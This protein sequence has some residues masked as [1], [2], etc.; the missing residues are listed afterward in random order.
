[1]AL[2][3]SEEQL[4]LPEGLQEE[5]TRR[6][7]TKESSEGRDV[8]LAGDVLDSRSELVRAMRVDQRA[9][10]FMDFLGKRIEDGA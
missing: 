8:D 4:G 7:W 9:G 2:L 1:M 10:S 6:F 5:E 3:S